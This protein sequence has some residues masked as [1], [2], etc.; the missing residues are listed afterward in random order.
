MP[1]PADCCPLPSKH[2]SKSTASCPEPCHLLPLSCISCPCLQ[3]RDGR[4]FLED[5]TD[6]VELDLTRAQTTSGFFTENTVVV[7]EGEMDASRKFHVR[8]LG[9]PPTEPRASR[10]RWQD[11]P[12][13]WLLLCWLLPLLLPLL[14]PKRRPPS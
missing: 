13:C 14:P 9:F 2:R 8:A 11:A 4:F 3:M 5:A 6:A 1:R 12:L 7:A 10:A